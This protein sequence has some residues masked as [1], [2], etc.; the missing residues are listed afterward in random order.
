[1]ATSKNQPP[2]TIN[3]D[4]FGDD[5]SFDQFVNVIIE[6]ATLVIAIGAGIGFEIQYSNAPWWA[7]FIVGIMATAIYLGTIRLAGEYGVFITCIKEGGYQVIDGFGKSIK[8][9]LYQ[10]STDPAFR[11]VGLWPF[12]RIRRLS[13]LVNDAVKKGG[14]DVGV[15][16]T[17]KTIID[18]TL[19][20]VATMAIP[21]EAEAASFEL[22]TFVLRVGIEVSPAEYH[23]END[24]LNPGQQLMVGTRSDAPLVRFLTLSGQKVVGSYLTTATYIMVAVQQII[25]GLAFDEWEDYVKACHNNGTSIFSELVGPEC[26]INQLLRAKVGTGVVHISAGN[27]DYPVESKLKEARKLKEINT[28][29]VAGNLVLAEGDA[30]T[31]RIRAEATNQAWL[32]YWRNLRAQGGSEAVVRAMTPNLTTIV[33]GDGKVV[34]TVTLK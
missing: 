25:Q 21:I 15:T 33:G 27:I 24:P 5:V 22:I 17:P 26:P 1:M 8:R 14:N 18:T 23:V 3:I 7:D 10:R 31:I 4:D 11:V 16:D 6:W 20:R 9:T 13:F 30:K 12:S 34:P 32:E 19:W 28:E 29:L 2:A